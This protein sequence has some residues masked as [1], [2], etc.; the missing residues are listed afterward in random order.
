VIKLNEHYQIAKPQYF[1]K[2]GVKENLG[3]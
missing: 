1:A 2:Q 3:P